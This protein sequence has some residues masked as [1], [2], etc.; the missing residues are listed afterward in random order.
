[1]LHCLNEIHG[2]INRKLKQAG[3]RCVYLTA[4]HIL[5]SLESEVRQESE[6]KHV[7]EKD[8]SHPTKGDVSGVRK[9]ARAWFLYSKEDYSDASTMLNQNPV[10]YY[11]IDDSYS[12]VE[13]ALRREEDDHDDI[14][15]TD[16]C[17]IF[18]FSQG[19]VFCHLLSKR[20]HEFSMHS[21]EEGTHFRNTEQEHNQRQHPCKRIKCSIMLGG[22][23]SMH[24][25][26]KQRKRCEHK[27]LE[28]KPIKVHSLHIIGEK[29]TRVP[30]EF[31]ERL[32]NCFSDPLK[33]AHKKGHIIPQ[34]SM[35]CQKIINFLDATRIDSSRSTNNR[36]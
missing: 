10:E 19:A 27:D 35:C 9:N 7:N 5:P 17:A 13:N 23:P 18:G 6:L 25:S 11:G 34:D 24:E 16:F 22:F 1:M 21:K 2:C 36:S 30:K 31:G 12:L 15:S 4:P 28:N 20:I 3:Y 26:N 33:Y 29:D 8:D 32:A 14:S